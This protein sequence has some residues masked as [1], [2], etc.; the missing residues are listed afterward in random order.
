VG[1]S[2]V[3]VACIA[4]AGSSDA[5]GDEPPAD[6]DPD[7][8]ATAVERTSN[9]YVMVS[10]PDELADILAHTFEAWRTFLHP[11]QRRVAYRPAYRG[12]ALVSGGA[13]TG[14]PLPRCTA[15]PHDPAQAARGLARVL[16]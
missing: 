4:K 2:A 11:R 5:A 7:D 8:L 15:R 1:H 6:V 14:K 9:R 10:G 16:C 12:P 3:K 13:G